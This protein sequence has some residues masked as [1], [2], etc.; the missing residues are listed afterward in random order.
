MTTAKMPDLAPSFKRFLVI[1]GDRGGAV[2]CLVC[3]V[4]IKF[5]GEMSFSTHV[6][7]C[8]RVASLFCWDVASTPR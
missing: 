8:K 5:V 4:E 6:D 2:L 3:F 7:L 1:L